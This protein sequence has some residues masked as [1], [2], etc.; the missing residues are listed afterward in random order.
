VH[1]KSRMIRKQ[2]LSCNSRDVP[3]TPFCEDCV[4]KNNVTSEN[5]PNVDGRILKVDPETNEV[6]GMVS[7]GTASWE[8]PL[9]V[10]GAGCGQWVKPGLPGNPPNTGGR[11]G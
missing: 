2:F 9:V 5:N 4:P 11:N 7:V 10:Y 6:A 1:D 8:S 3:C